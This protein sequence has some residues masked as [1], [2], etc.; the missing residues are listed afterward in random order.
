MCKE[1]DFRTKSN[2]NNVLI[3]EAL[4]KL[5]YKKSPTNL[6]NCVSFKAL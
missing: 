4:N 5:N 6:D 3:L 1:I 2:F